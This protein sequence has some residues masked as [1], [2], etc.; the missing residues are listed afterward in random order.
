MTATFRKSRPKRFKI[1]D[2]V[3]Q[4]M[5]LQEAENIVLAGDSNKTRTVRQW[6]VGGA[7]PYGQVDSPDSPDSQTQIA[8]SQD[9]Q[10][11]HTP[12]IQQDRHIVGAQ[13][14]R[15]QVQTV[16]TQGI[17]WNDPALTDKLK[18]L[19]LDVLKEQGISQTAITPDPRQAP[20]LWRT[21]NNVSPISLRLQTELIKRSRQA[22]KAKYGNLSLNRYI[23]LCLFDLIGRPVDLT[24]PD[25]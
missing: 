18:S 9:E 5:T 3:N 19:V 21:M 24:L 14:A 22:L 15:K 1:A 10:T 11:T 23:E 16:I 4:G 2:L 7:Y 6:Q 13:G 8:F 25:E 17:N 20:K 12:P